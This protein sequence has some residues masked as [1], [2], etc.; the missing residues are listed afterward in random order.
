MVDEK[1]LAEIYVKAC[2]AY[3]FLKSRV[4]V[5]SFTSLTCLEFISAYGVRE[6]S[7]L[8]VVYIV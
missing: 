4:P 8:I 7:N 1:Q 2:S 5:L 6:Y 3:V